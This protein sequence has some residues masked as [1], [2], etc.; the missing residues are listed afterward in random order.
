MRWS[1]KIGRL[2]GIGIHVHA[3][4]L[5]LILLILFINLREGKS[6]ATAAGGEECLDQLNP[7]LSNLGFAVIQIPKVWASFPFGEARMRAVFML[8]AQIIRMETTN[9]NSL[10]M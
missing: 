2:A 7:G 6:L 3:T 10:G 1:W 9:L 4:F 5:L 8:P